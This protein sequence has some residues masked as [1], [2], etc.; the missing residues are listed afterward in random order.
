MGIHFEANEEHHDT[1]GAF[2]IKALLHPANA[3]EHPS[4]VVSDTD[5]TINEKRAILASWASDA[6]AVPSM[7]ALRA[8]SPG[9]RPVTFDEIMD[10]L[11]ALDEQA[12]ALAKPLPHYRRVL[13]RRHTSP[14]RRYG[15]RHPPLRTNG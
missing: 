9:V 4:D 11:R 7:P 1:D 8:F 14:D 6:C 5:L 2:D 15:R 10:A 12:R 3:F 13:S